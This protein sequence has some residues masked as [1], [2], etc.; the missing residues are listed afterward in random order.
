AETWDP[1]PA[2]RAAPRGRGTRRTI[3]SQLPGAPL[4]LPVRDSGS[5]FGD[6]RFQLEERNASCDQLVFPRKDPPKSH[7]D[8]PAQCRKEIKQYRTASKSNDE[9]GE[10][11][12]KNYPSAE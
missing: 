11:I 1:H 7:C 8:N 5:R 12:G 6:G 10:Q 2:L 4:Q 3:S 9:I